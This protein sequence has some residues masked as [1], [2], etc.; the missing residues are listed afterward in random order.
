M[1]RIPTLL[2]AFTTFVVAIYTLAIRPWHLRWGAAD[3]EV[4]DPLPGDE[5]VQ[6]AKLNA[7]HAVSIQAPPA[8]VW[9]WLVQIGQGRGGFYS[10]DWI[11]NAMGLEIHSSDSILPEHQD[12]QVGDVI[13]LAP[14]GS[15]GL[16]V[17]MLEPERVLVLHGDTRIPDQKSGPPMRPG[18]YLVAT[19]GFYIFPQPDGG[20]RL[21]ERWRSDWAPSLLNTFFY[22]LFL[23]PGAF[24]MER[25]MLLGIKERAER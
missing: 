11:E 1:K 21:V 19:W 25:K 13:P 10:Y 5:L 4:D 3:E 8:Q 20:T 9:S 15:F 7:T 17:A 23:E 16:P 18:D 24:L 14:D 2:A 6:D 12:L 22:R